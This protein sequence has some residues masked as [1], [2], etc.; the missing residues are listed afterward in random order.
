[1]LRPK[2][3]KFRKCFKNKIKSNIDIKKNKLC[4][5]MYGIQALE[6]GR[7][8]ARQIESIRRTI[9]GKLKRKGKIWIRIFPDKP[10]SKKPAEVRMGKGKGEVYFW[11]AL[12]K[13]GTILYEIS[14]ENENLIN[15]ALFIS[16]KKLGLKTRII[17][18]F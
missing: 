1:M 9:I 18:N 13:P 15:E 16:K 4:F 2:N 12:I 6:K 5:G 11:C 3:T 10:I 17:K 14:G 8:N 7:I